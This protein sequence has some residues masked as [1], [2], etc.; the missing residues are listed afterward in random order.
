[1]YHRFETYTRCP[2]AIDYGDVSDAPLQRFLLEE[3]IENSLEKQSSSYNMSSLV[4]RVYYQLRPLFPVSIR[5]H[6]QKIALRGWKDIR[7]PAWP[8]DT[9]VDDLVAEGFRHLLRTGDLE[10]VPFIWFWPRGHRYAAMMTH[11]VETAAGRD[12]TPEMMRMESRH[13]IVSSFEVVPEERYEV[14]D[15][16]LET[17][18]RGGCEICLH[19]LNHDGHLFDDPEEFARRAAKIGHYAKSFD[20]LGFRSPVMYRDLDWIP[21]L[22]VSYDMSVPNTARLDPQRGGCCTVMPYFLDD[23]L[24]L[25]LTTIQDYPLL[26]ILNDYS[27]DLWR[28]QSMLVRSRF[29]L[30]SF[31]VHPDYA[32]SA[33][34]SSLYED[35]LAYLADLRQNDDLWIALPREVDAWWRER[36]SLQVELHDD[37]WNIVGEGSDRAVLAFAR[38]DAGELVYELETG[39]VFRVEDPKPADVV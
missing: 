19:G 20:V 12:F 16:Y 17:I 18:R 29:G 26:N 31:I 21:R 5:K 25:P 2:L 7:F 38:L 1:M 14:P 35:L 32:S 34:A 33:R 30:L 28:E 8:L 37:R 36:S 24:E 27:L 9:S 23:V 11:D 4:R 22:P 13:G 10:A 6:L 15:E 3:Y 39:E